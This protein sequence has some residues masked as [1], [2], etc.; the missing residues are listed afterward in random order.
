MNPFIIELSPV[1]V[2]DKYSISNRVNV[3]SFSSIDFLG[4]KIYK[5]H[6]NTT[7]MPENILTLKH[8]LEKHEA[9]EPVRNPLKTSK[10]PIN[11]IF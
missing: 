6:N 7:I 8:L 5:M 10:K 9:S 4:F 2:V 11:L 3:R 1:I